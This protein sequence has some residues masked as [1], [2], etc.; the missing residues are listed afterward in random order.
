MN[1]THRKINN[2]INKILKTFISEKYVKVIF[3]SYLIR[4]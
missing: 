3:F 4:Y 2:M 1:T